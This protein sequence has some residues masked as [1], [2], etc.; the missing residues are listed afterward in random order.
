MIGCDDVGGVLLG[1][2]MGCVLD[3]DCV[4]LGWVMGCVFLGWVIHCW[5]WM[6]RC[7]ECEG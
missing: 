4:E 5:V 6:V 3:D 2:V 7:D 1:W